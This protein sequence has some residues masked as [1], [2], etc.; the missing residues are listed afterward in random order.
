MSIQVATAILKLSKPA[1]RRLRTALLSWVAIWPLITLLLFIGEP[2]LAGLA[3]PIKTLLVTA[4]LVP[5]MSFLVMPFLTRRFAS[6]LEG[7]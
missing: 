7:A 4:L 3:M 5:V 2:L 1:L 6:W